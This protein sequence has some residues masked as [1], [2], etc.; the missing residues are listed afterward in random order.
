MLN[1]RFL[2]NIDDER[3]YRR[4]YPC[5]KNGLKKTG[6]HVL[7][8]CRM[9]FTDWS[10]RLCNFQNGSEY[11]K[12]GIEH[13]CGIY[14]YSFSES[15][16][17]KEDEIEPFRDYSRSEMTKDANPMIDSVCQLFMHCPYAYRSIDSKYFRNMLIK[18]LTLGASIRPYMNFIKALNRKC[19]CSRMIV[20]GR[21]DFDERLKK[22][23]EC[24]YCCF[25]WNNVRYCCRNFWR[26]F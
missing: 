2:K 23:I 13:K 19:L 6:N 11:Y 22:Y 26:V 21:E 3:K 17:E 5:F 24:A 20:F 14:V 25:A 4:F 8:L 16:K 12:K 9:P 7:L 10:G 18:T 1:V 15:G